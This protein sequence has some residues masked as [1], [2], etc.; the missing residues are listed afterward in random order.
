M[1][2]K[3][4][5]KCEN[6]VYDVD[7]NAAGNKIKEITDSQFRLFYTYSTFTI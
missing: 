7:K 2:S 1:Y 5:S 4:S 6:E 3:I